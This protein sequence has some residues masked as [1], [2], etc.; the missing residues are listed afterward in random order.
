MRLLRPRAIQTKPTVS[1]VI[2]CY[3]YGGYLAAAV[4]SVLDQ[5]GV[6]ADVLIVDDASP[7]GSVEEARR[8]A[9]R[10]DRVSVLEHEKYQGHIATYNDGLRRVTG[11]YVVLMSAD[12]LLT[13][14]SLARACALLESRSDVSFVYGHAVDF[15][16][17]P[18]VPRT[19]PTTWTI[20]GGREWVE[21]LCRRG[22]NV[23][24]SP[25]VVM[26]TDALRAVGLYDPE[27]PH[28]AD[29]H[30]WL[31]AALVGN[32]GRVNGAD[33]AF[34]RLHDKN[35]HT[36]SFATVA[37]DIRERFRVWEKLIG[38]ERYPTASRMRWKALST[39]SLARETIRVGC[40]ADD[41]RE[42]GDDRSLDQ[43]ADLATAIWPDVVRTA[44]WQ[45][46]KR[47]SRGDES[48]WRRRANL[49][50]WS[51]RNKVRWHRLRVIG[52]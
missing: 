46:L 50:E 27:L 26:R 44:A 38:D 42:P 16:D 9:R 31:K 47:R 19:R 51:L 35:M 34:Y 25:E 10:D 8:L 17:S 21:R 5:P 37:E 20:W 1:V 30:M 2:P 14:G 18:P 7:D 28:T 12:D 52:T 36:S 39:R 4:R 3:N 23:I 6:A 41:S 22:G 15:R 48:N 11:K 13:P 29:L 33:Q 24:S 49:A 43:Y 45:Q 40:V 32:V